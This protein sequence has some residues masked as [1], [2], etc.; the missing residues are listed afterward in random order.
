MKEH[1]CLAQHSTTV[2]ICDETKSKIVL[3][4]SAHS[5]RVVLIGDLLV[6]LLAPNEVSFRTRRENVGAITRSS[7]ELMNVI[8]AQ[9]DRANLLHIAHSIDLIGIKDLK[10]DRCEA[11]R[12]TVAIEEHT[13]ATTIRHARGIDRNEANVVINVLDE[14]AIA[15]AIANLVALLNALNDRIKL[16]NSGG[17]DRSSQIRV[18]VA[19]VSS[20][21]LPFEL[22]LAVDNALSDKRDASLC[23]ASSLGGAS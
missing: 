10:R 17:T 18:R 22:L 23:N 6:D 14:N 5:P 7:H 11:I 4:K 1:L 2:L 19:A 9:S 20:D 13:A 12:E 21:L 15:F 8:A 16:P 3:K